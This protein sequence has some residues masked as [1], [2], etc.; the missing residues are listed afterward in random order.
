MDIPKEEVFVINRKLFELVIDLLEL[1]GELR[2]IESSG[3]KNSTKLHKIRYDNTIHNLRE[4]EKQ[5]AQKL[6]NGLELGDLLQAVSQKL[7]RVGLQPT[8]TITKK[9]KKSELN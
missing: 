7:Y 9:N 6:P 2:A 5:I 1:H 4:L 3:K 8:N